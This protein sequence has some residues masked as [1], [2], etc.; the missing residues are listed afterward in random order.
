MEF[1]SVSC[2]I[3]KISGRIFVFHDESLKTYACT[4][5]RIS[6]MNRVTGGKPGKG[7]LSEIILP[8]NR[9]H[10]NRGVRG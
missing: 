7:E 2:L 3:A 4:A 8:E 10:P 1:L 6:G 9:W 5:E